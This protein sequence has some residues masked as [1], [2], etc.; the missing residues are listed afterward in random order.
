MN[1]LSSPLLWFGIALWFLFSKKKPDGGFGNTGGS[2]VTPVI[3]PDIQ[4]PDGSFIIQPTINQAKATSLA[5]Q[6]HEEFSEF[7]PD[8]SDIL[9]LLKGL[10]QADYVNVYNA[11]GLKSVRLTG[12]HDLTY[13]LI[14]ILDNTA[15]L[16]K[17]KQQFPNIF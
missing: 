10:N 5:Y 14:E 16:N 13:W 8:N 1:F 2:F 17:L 12:A 11:F 4:N 7:I 6:L 3:R 15:D 9:N